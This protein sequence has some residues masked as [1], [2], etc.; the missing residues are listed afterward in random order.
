MKHALGIILVI[1]ISSTIER[2]RS[3]ADINN[4]VAIIGGLSYSHIWFDNQAIRLFKGDLQHTDPTVSMADVQT[5]GGYDDNSKQ[6]KVLLTKNGELVIS[7]IK[8]SDYLN[9]KLQIDIGSPKFDQEFKSAIGGEKG[10]NASYLVM[11]LN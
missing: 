4:V 10:Y 6:V 3:K 7:D 8:W 11:E 1:L 5:F 2:S 9:L